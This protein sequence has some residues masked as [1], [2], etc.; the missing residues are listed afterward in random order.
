MAALGQVTPASVVCAVLGCVV[1][2]VPFIAGKLLEEERPATEGG[3]DEKPF[4]S[5]L[6]ASDTETLSGDDGAER[7]RLPYL[8]NLKYIAQC[9]VVSSHYV[10][11]FYAFPFENEWSWVPGFREMVLNP[12][13][14]AMYAF[15]SGYCSK[16]AL[17]PQRLFR[18]VSSLI[19]PFW[20]VTELTVLAHCLPFSVRAKDLVTFAQCYAGAER[21]SHH[22]WYLGSL[23]MWRLL[24]PALLLFKRTYVISTCLSISL[25]FPYAWNVK[26]SPVIWWLSMGLHFLPYFAMGLITPP[27]TLHRA[28]EQHTRMGWLQLGGVVFLK[29]YIC[30]TLLSPA[31]RHFFKQEL[32]PYMQSASYQQCCS[33][34]LDDPLREHFS[35]G[36][37]LEYYLVWGRKAVAQFILASVLAVSICVFVP[38]WPSRMTRWGT[39]SLVAYTLHDVVLKGVRRSMDAADVDGRVQSS[40]WVYWT[41]IFATGPIFTAALS[42]D[43][44]AKQSNATQDTYMSV[45]P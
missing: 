23:V 31:F 25:F 28:V 41:V 36:A 44:V 3:G 34:P 9:L 20:L 8:D 35:S 45:C 13:C 38:R 19:V 42:T 37:K 16:G 7:K 21:P 15:T 18:V 6:G 40:P 4:R 2:A 32:H 26:P 24:A 14:I 39:H 22:L 27:R 10:S 33:P 43:F 5:L 1:L 30:L 11:P 17:A 29:V 12:P